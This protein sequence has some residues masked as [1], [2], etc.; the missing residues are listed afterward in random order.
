MS[1]HFHLLLTPARKR[2]VQDFMLKLGTSYSLYFNK[3]YDRTGGLFEGSYKAR[4]ADSDR[5]LK[6]LFAYIH[7]NPFRSK[8]EEKRIID[9]AQLYTFEHSSLPDYLGAERQVKKILAPS[10]FPQYFQ[11]IGEHERELMEWLD[12][13]E[14]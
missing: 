8:T 13:D 10:A 9:K 11:S 3:K 6:Y 14:I 2:G 1:N 5:Y 4:W 7:L 12:Y